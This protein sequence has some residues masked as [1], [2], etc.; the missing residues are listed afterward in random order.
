MIWIYDLSTLLQ[1]SKSIGADVNWGV[2]FNDVKDVGT[3]G[4]V[5]VFLFL[6]RFYLT[7]QNLPKY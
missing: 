7:K 2:R 6:A 4:T 3:F 5:F 1:E